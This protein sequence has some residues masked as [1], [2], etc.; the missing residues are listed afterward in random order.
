MSNT[1][2]STTYNAAKINIITLRKDGEVDVTVSLPDTITLTV[3]L[4]DKI[5]LTVLATNSTSVMASMQYTG[6]LHHYS[7]GE[8]ITFTTMKDSNNILRI[9]TLTL[10]KPNNKA[11]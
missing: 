5:P 6:I 4:Y 3:N 11:S 9:E 10:N 8:D 1:S 7:R 2:K